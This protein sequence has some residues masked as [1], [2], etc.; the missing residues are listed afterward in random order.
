MPKGVYVRTKPSSKKGV[1]K[2]GIKLE[3]FDSYENYKIACV[4]AISK[5]Y[6]TTKK[7]NLSKAKRWYKWVQ[8]KG[9]TVMNSH[10]AKRRA[11]KL[12]RTVPW[13]DLKAIKQFYINCPK[14]YHV[15]HIVPLQGVNISGLHVLNNLQYLTK[16]QNSSKGNKWISTN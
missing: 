1:N 11:S 14:G 10:N 3:D 5:M 12:Q 9:R 6:D 13:A 16:S 7:G 4:N 8:G 15:D 2:V